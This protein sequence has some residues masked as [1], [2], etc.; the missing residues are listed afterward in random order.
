MLPLFFFL[1]CTL[2]RLKLARPTFPFLFRSF[3]SSIAA[4]VKVAVD[5]PAG[6]GKSSTARAVAKRL[7]L[8][9]IDTGAMYRSVALAC[10]KQ[11]VNVEEKEAVVNVAKNVSIGFSSKEDALH[12]LL[13]GEDVTDE[14]RTVEVNKKVS[15][16]ASNAEVRKILVAHQQHLGST[17]P[18][19]V[20]MDGRDIGT[21]VFPDAE[22]KVYMEA[23]SK[24]RAERRLKEMRE[25]GN[26]DITVDEVEADI[27][28]RDE[29]DSTR[30]AS[31]LKPAEDAVH[32]DTTSL[33][34]A[35]QVEK[36]CELIAPHLPSPPLE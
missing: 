3:H 26:A 23:S 13:D 30:E 32:I 1:L 35:D 9:Y 19:G 2:F 8:T 28:R 25:K 16:V 5:G 11:G 12:V 10:I 21:V 27:I 34:F 14:I 4:M 7:Q 6:S 17:D 36:V 33:V 24:M 20:V 15:P 18:R 22:V 31:P 29:V